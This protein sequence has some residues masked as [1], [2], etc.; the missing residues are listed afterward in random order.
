MLSTTTK[1]E[2][3]SDLAFGLE[4][5]INTI[6]IYF[7]NKSYSSHDRSSFILWHADLLLGN[8]HETNS[9]TMAHKQQ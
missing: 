3:L 4:I 2:K 7:T 5:N 8:D 1:D 6:S 9:E